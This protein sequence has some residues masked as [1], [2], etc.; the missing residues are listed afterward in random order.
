[1]NDA[2]LKRNVVLSDG[3]EAGSDAPKPTRCKS[4]GK[5]KASPLD[6]DVDE[7]LKAMMEIDDGTRHSP[8]S[9]TFSD[10]TSP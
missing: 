3:D 1:M 2:R 9:L 10:G 8:S 6:S 7:D 5:A 4:A